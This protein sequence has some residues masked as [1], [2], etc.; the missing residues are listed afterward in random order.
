MTWHDDTFFE[1]I[2]QRV[3]HLPWWLNVSLLLALL[4]APFG[5]AFF[6]RMVLLRLPAWNWR[7]IVFPLV[8]AVYAFAVAP[9]IWRAE[10]A[11]VAGLRPLAQGAPTAGVRRRSTRGDWLAFGLGA[12]GGVPLALSFM[13]A[14]LHW[15]DYYLV[16]SYSIMYGA[17]TWLIY[18]A[19]ASAR[20][21][22]LTLRTLRPHNPFDLSPFEPVG[23]QALV[24][25]LIFVG[26]ITISL[27][28]MYTPQH[29][30]GWANLR[31]LLIYTV[32]LLTTLSVFFGVM[33]P[34][35]RILARVKAERQEA[36]Q[37]LIARAF[38]PFAAALDAGDARRPEAVELE[39]WLTLARRLEQAPTWPHNVVMLRTLA[40]SGLSPVCVALF[41]VVGIYL[42]E[43]G[44]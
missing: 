10:R 5:V 36:L 23:R 44:L 4:G 24:L 6:E 8:G 40:L 22:A 29:F 39:T 41:R 26:G 20:V 1:R 35:H 28:F 43:G 14:Q 31:I 19:L 25:A 15:L 9:A 11:V 33:W 21:T 17:L 34:A 27:F 18:T 38:G 2:I 13:P 16:L 42:G 32:L 30:F 12:L 3:I 37:R 7:S